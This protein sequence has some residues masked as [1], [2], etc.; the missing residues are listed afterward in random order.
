VYTSIAKPLVADLFKGQNS[1]IFAY[2]QTGSGKS[3]SIF[4]VEGHEGIV[5]WALREIFELKQ[6]NE[7]LKV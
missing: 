2:G 1:T 7:T 5:P 3:Y 4:G 6:E